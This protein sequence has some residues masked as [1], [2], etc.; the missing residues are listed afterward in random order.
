[1]RAKDGV[2]RVYKEFVNYKGEVTDSF[3]VVEA[4]NRSWIQDLIKADVEFQKKHPL[5]DRLRVVTVGKGE[6]IY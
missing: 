4:I 2:V 1:M 6:E 3:L 5:G